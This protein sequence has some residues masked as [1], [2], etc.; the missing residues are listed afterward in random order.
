MSIEENRTCVVCCFDFNFHFGSWV[1]QRIS[2]NFKSLPSEWFIAIASINLSV[3]FLWNVHYNRSWSSYLF[4][5]THTQTHSTEHKTTSWF[6]SLLHNV[7]Q[8]ENIIHNENPV[9]ARTINSNIGW[10]TIYLLFV[11]QGQYFSSGF[12]CDLTCRRIQC[13]KY[14][15]C[16]FHWPLITFQS[17]RLLGNSSCCLHLFT[18]LIDTKSFSVAFQFTN[19]PNLNGFALL[20]LFQ[21]N[22]VSHN[23]LYGFVSFWISIC[24]CKIFSAISYYLECNLRFLINVLY[25]SCS[26]TRIFKHLRK[27]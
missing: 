20:P 2:Q 23:E 17:M 15:V 19:W 9:A 27:F 18:C 16:S 11:T 8:S 5:F 12:G 3:F 26:N 7:K 6:G 24:S 1:A 4:A 13:P 21:H 25:C 22:T 10:N 14:A